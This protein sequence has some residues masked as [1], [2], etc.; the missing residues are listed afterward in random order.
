MIGLGYVGLPLCVALA[1]QTKVV[2]FDVDKDRISELNKKYDRTREIDQQQLRLV[3]KN[4]MF[5]TKESLLDDVDTYIV[6]VPTPVDEFNIP[7]LNAIITATSTIAKYL[8]PNDLVI[9]ES[10]VYPG[11]TEERCIPILESVSGL[12]INKDFGVGYSPE[13]I[14]PGDKDRTISDITKIVSGSNHEWT[15]EVENIYKPIISAGVHVASSIKVAEAAKVIENTQRDVNIALMNELA[16]LFGKL[17]INTTDVLDAASTKWN[18]MNFSPGLVGGHC[19]GVDPYYLV[20]KAKEIG[21]LPEIITAG[22]RINDHMPH[23]VIDKLIRS[24]F[25]QGG[26]KHNLN[27]LILGAT[28][29]ENC[30]DLRNSKVLTMFQ[31]L[32]SM[33]INVDVYDPIANR[34]ELSE[35]YT[36]SAVQE[37]IPGRYNAAIIA[38]AHDQFV[39]L[40]ISR[41]ENSLIGE[42]IIFD[43]KSIFNDYP[44]SLKL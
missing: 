8:K 19:I 40:G 4:T 21:Y 1:K 28:F 5:T 20:H 12:N 23:H 9:Y 37:I 14:N 43:V 29:K 27:V 7:D 42:K 17:K 39:D 25:V 36:T 3:S 38:V 24:F 13:R 6:T 18:F 32:K 16:I 11:L 22:R 2:G 33:D 35:I 26:Q 10:T 30:P 15:R 34:E 31:E 44:N 41:I